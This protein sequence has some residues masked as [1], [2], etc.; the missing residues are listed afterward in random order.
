MPGAS[1]RETGHGRAISRLVTEGS[2]PAQGTCAGERTHSVGATSTISTRLEA[3][4]VHIGWKRKGKKGKETG[5][6]LKTR[7]K[8]RKKLTIGHI[9]IA[10]GAKPAGGTGATDRSNGVGSTDF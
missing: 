3:A 10:K 9:S 2:T 5:E 8:E 7:G 6:L 4:F 1:R